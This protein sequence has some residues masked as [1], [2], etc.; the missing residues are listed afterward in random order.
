MGWSIEN[1]AVDLQMKTTHLIVEQKVILAKKDVDALLDDILFLQ[2]QMHALSIDLQAFIETTVTYIS[3][4]E[5]N[6]SYILVHELII[7]VSQ[8]IG[9]LLSSIKSTGKLEE[10]FEEFVEPFAV[11]LSDI[12][13]IIDDLRYKIEGDQEMNELLAGII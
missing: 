12:D 3:Q 10:C 8:I 13:E 2:K 1:N 6:E 11:L 9:R 7:P 5:N 4:N